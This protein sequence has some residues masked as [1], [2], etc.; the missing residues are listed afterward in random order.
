M[1]LVKIS[2]YAEGYYSGQTYTEEY[3]IKEESYNILKEKIDNTNIFIGDL[4]GKHSEVEATLNINEY[5][6]EDIL[7]NNIETERDGDSL[8]WKLEEIYKSI[9][10]DIYKEIDEVNNYLSSLDTYIT[11]EVKVKKSQKEL[12]EYF[13]QDLN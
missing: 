6:E 7:N 3:F 8:L 12:V 11:F 5:S 2:I 1:N 13:I 9:G 4:D 10:L